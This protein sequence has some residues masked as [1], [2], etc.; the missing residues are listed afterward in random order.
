MSL[1]E[2]RAR[3]LR[4]YD[5][6]ATSEDDCRS[7]ERWP[8]DTSVALD[9]IARLEA[10]VL[11]IYDVAADYSSEDNWGVYPIGLFG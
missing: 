8:C 5:S 1:E 11:E 2:V 4:G 7:G 6:S 3:H 10:L 9:R